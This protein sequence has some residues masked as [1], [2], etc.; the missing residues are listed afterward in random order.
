LHSIEHPECPIN[1]GLGRLSVATDDA[2]FRI[3]TPHEEM[4][5]AARTMVIVIMHS[6]PATFTPVVVA[7]PVPVPVPSVAAVIPPPMAIIIVIS[8]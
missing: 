2:K 1:T 6:A 3:P 7:I 8:R 4:G 5:V